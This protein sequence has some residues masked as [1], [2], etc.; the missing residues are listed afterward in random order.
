FKVRAQPSGG[1]GTHGAMVTA[2]PFHE[3]PGLPTPHAC[4]G[5]R[6]PINTPARYRNVAAYLFETFKPEKLACARDVFHRS[7][8]VIVGHRSFYEG[9]T[10]D[11]EFWGGSEFRE[12]KLKIIFAHGDI[13]I[14]IPNDVEVLV[15]QLV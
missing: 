13:G 4:S 1:R 3:C 12:Q 15:S 9:G 5:H 7:E 6:D 8:A 2:D 14:Q 11:A 10:R